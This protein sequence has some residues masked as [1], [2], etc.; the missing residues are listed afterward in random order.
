MRPVRGLVP[1]GHRPER[2]RGRC[3]CNLLHD[4][5][6]FRDCHNR[7]LSDSLNPVFLFHPMQDLPGRQHVDGKW[8]SGTIWK[9]MNPLMSEAVRTCRVTSCNAWKTPHGETGFSREAAV[10][11]EEPWASCGQKKKERTCRSS[12]SWLSPSG[13]MLLRAVRRKGHSQ[14]FLFAFFRKKSQS[15]SSSS[16]AS[17]GSSEDSGAPISSSGKQL[18][19]SIS[20]LPPRMLMYR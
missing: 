8:K 10:R 17:A 14:L 7:L 16:S 4:S 12:P 11:P 5:H 6:E 9:C 3:A 1:R 13:C 15:F 2:H 20:S 19:I 18:L